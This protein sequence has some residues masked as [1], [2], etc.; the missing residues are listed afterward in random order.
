MKNI[1]LNNF[2][3]GITAF[4]FFEMYFFSSFLLEKLIHDLDSMESIRI[5]AVARS[6]KEDTFYKSSYC[7]PA[8]YLGVKQDYTVFEE[9]SVKDSMIIWHTEAKILWATTHPAGGRL[10]VKEVKDPAGNVRGVERFLTGEVN[11]PFGT[12]AFVEDRIVSETLKLHNAVA[13]II[14]RMKHS[15][16]MIE[17]FHMRYGARLKEGK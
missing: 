8:R 14:P 5:S 1:I 9:Y 11:A 17:Q 6:R 7:V 16:D 12:P 13:E 4:Q 15:I 3:P 10:E 2:I